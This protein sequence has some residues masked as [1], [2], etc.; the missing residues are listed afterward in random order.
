MLKEKFLQ[1]THNQRGTSFP[2]ANAHTPSHCNE[3]TGAT[4]QLVTKE[5]GAPALALST[6]RGAAPQKALPLRFSVTGEHRETVGAL[7]LA[8]FWE[9]LVSSV[10]SYPNLREPVPQPG[11]ISNKAEVLTSICLCSASYFLID[12]A[13]RSGRKWYYLSMPF[14]IPNS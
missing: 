10:S 13:H 9:E 2:H 6:P 3:R 14:Q 8:S 4:L 11:F 5:A 1:I 7:N 12:F